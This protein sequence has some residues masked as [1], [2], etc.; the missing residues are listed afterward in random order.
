MKRTLRLL[1][2]VFLFI[3]L[4]LFV[5]PKAQA[6]SLI[7]SSDIIG[8]PAPPPTGTGLGHLDLILFENSGGGTGNVSGTHNYDNSNSD[9]P[10]G[11]PNTTA[12]ESYITSI[13]D[14][15]DFYTYNF[16]SLTN[17]IVL[18][19]DINETGKPQDI[20]LDSLKIVR[21][22]DATYGD[23]RDTPSTTDVTTAQ[24][25]LT[26][27]IYTYTGGTLIAALSGGPLTLEQLYTGGGRTD[28]FIL[29]GINPFDAAYLPSDRILFDWESSRHNDGGENV[30]ISGTYRKEDFNGVIP[31]P[32]SLSLLGLGLLGLIGIG[33]KK[34]KQV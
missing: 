26:N 32:A 17:E 7:D 11:N 34:V 9:F 28:Y 24:Q 8:F 14:L 20:S 12:N 29:T 23:N 1:S 31:E 5:S 30:Y 3:V 2:I 27:N 16:P 13:G 19:L 25:N 4:G 21:N 10:T 33:R 6:V 15:R 22:Y 18:F